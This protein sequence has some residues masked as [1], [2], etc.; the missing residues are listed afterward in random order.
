MKIVIVE[1]DIDVM[2]GV[3]RIISTLANNLC[4]NNEVYVISKHKNRET[5]FFHYDDKVKIIYLKDKRKNSFFKRNKN[6]FFNKLSDYISYKFSNLIV[7]YINDDVKKILDSADCIIFGRVDVY[8]DFISFLKKKKIKS[9]IIVRDAINLKLFEKNKKRKMLKYF[10]NNVD[11]FIVS[12][13]ESI[14][15]YNEF[16]PKDM[17][18]KIHKIYN[19]LGITP[20]GKYNFESKT[21]V[22]LGRFDIQKGYDDLIHAFKIVCNC[23]PDWKLKIYGNGPLKESMEN[24]IKSLGLT[25]NIELCNSTNNIVSVLNN[26]SIYVMTSR[27]EG[28]ANMLV[29]A[30]SCGMPVISY[31]WYTGVDDIINDKK[32]GEIV[33][34]KD[35]DLY[36]L[37]K[38]NNENVENLAKTII[39]YISNPDMCDKYSIEAKKI[40]NSRTTEVVIS[41][42]EKIINEGRR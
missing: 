2:G 35:R 37:H 25:N 13:N 38:D 41:N 4:K 20:K 36:F 42:W 34:L 32:N 26:S 33:Y 19:P 22:S 29:E 40:V 1:Q 11:D 7:H 21:I 27:Y 10:P 3:E 18:M 16:F 39:N 17:K 9:R 28:Y 5:T 15:L 31:N 24:L 14:N 23:F 12:S 8:L 6:N 30:M